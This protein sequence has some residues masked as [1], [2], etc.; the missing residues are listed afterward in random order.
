MSHLPRIL[1]GHRRLVSAV[2]R[3]S[4]LLSAKPGRR[5]EV[6]ETTEPRVLRVVAM[7]F[8]LPTLP[9]GGANIRECAR[10]LIALSGVG[11][12]RSQIFEL[13]LAV[14]PSSERAAAVAL[15]ESIASDA[16]ALLGVERGLLVIHGDRHHIH[17]HLALPNDRGD[18]R[19]LVL[20]P[21]L[22]CK[23]RRDLDSWT[24]APVRTAW[25]TGRELEHSLV[26]L[27]PAE[28]REEIRQQRLGIVWDQHGHAAAIRDLRD[29]RRRKAR[30]AAIE[31]LWPGWAEGVLGPALQAQQPTQ[32]V[33][34]PPAPNPAEAPPTSPRYPAAMVAELRGRL[35]ALTPHQ[36]DA[37]VR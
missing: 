21:D 14:E 32:P 5:E 6:P 25:G 4:Y 13:L 29:R 33:V 10:R 31:R 26:R 12:R 24:D 2:H 19:C 27:R 8:D 36:R 15:V 28:L 7:G 9:S 16:L 20:A 35:A 30:I 22:F 11:R 18:G 1:I 23:L 34:A 37:P 3:V 17:G